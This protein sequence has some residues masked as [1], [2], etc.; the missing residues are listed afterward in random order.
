MAGVRW[1]IKAYWQLFGYNSIGGTK[2]LEDPGKTVSVIIFHYFNSKA[3]K[4]TPKKLPMVK[5][6]TKMQ[7]HLDD[8]VKLFYSAQKLQFWTILFPYKVC[9]WEKNMYKQIEIPYLLMVLLSITLRDHPF[10]TSAFFRGEGSKIMKI[11]R[12]LKWMVPYKLPWAGD[13]A[14]IEI[15]WLIQKML[16][17]TVMKRIL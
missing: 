17:K 8:L 6:I 10:K 15:S 16:D 1:F 5:K 14:S 7:N 9:E 4:K 2:S 13:F 12:R 11:C 3:N